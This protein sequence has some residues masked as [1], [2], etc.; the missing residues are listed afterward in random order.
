MTKSIDKHNI[1]EYN[2]EIASNLFA[3]R[4][5]NFLQQFG[6]LLMMKHFQQVRILRLELSLS[7]SKYHYT[8]IIPRI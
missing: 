3:R 1:R 8:S 2:I 7:L 4:I 6:K 5:E